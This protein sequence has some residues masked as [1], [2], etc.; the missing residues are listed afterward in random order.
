MTKLSSF[1]LRSLLSADQLAIIQERDDQWIQD[2][3]TQK[4][5]HE[6]WLKEN[7]AEA[8][9]IRRMAEPNA[10]SDWIGLP[11]TTEAEYHAALQRLRESGLLD[12]SN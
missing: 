11:E 7:S 5:A 4:L 3:I 9:A 6:S 1:D 2:A 10:P 12:V 8:K